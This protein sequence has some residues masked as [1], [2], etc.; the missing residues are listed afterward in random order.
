MTTSGLRALAATVAIAAALLGEG[1]PD[2]RAS[3]GSGASPAPAGAVPPA[4]APEGDASSASGAGS[5]PE[6]RFRSAGAAYEAGRYEEAV[7]LYERLLAEGYDDARIHYNLGNARF[8]QGRL[9]EA[10]LGYERALARNPADADA[11]ENLAY[12]NLLTIDKVGPLEE[13][14]PERILA[15]FEERFDADRAIALFAAL[16]VLGSALALPLW[17]SRSAAA[18][19]RLRTGAGIYLTLAALSLG[20]AALEIM[21]MGG[22]DHAVVLA[23]T[24]DGR[25]APTV[26]GTVLFTVHEGL[27]VE[28]RSAREGWIQVALPNGL[29][30]WIEAAQAESI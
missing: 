27:K 18:R 17:S 10:I 24:V 26:D 21:R 29:V 16:A 25:S 6:A 12:A 11:R 4:A 3:E 7:S 13:S 8:K 14:F 19:R 22:S 1:S 20:V 9:G 28:V 15:S 30:G 5:S 23:A 2:M